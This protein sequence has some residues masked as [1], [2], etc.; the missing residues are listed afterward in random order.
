M[1]YDT[2]SDFDINKLVAEAQGL[3][4][5]YSEDR[6]MHLI[7]TGQTPLISGEP[8]ETVAYIFDYCNDP[9]YAW[10]II[11]ENK[12]SIIQTVSPSFCGA[13]KNYGSGYAQSI[14]AEVKHE[15]P[16]RAAMLVY[17]QMK[18]SEQ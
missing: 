9:T 17:L 2:L 6:G 18:E 14:T 7:V 8:I 13:I 12:I 3:E 1:D 16:L 4:I 5:I 15:N 10:P 11:V